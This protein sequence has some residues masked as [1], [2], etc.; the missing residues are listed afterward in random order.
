MQQPLA[1]R[2][3][4]NIL[5]EFFGHETLTSNHG[6]INKMLE[7]KT[8]VS[9][10][11]YGPPGVGKT[12]LAL[13]ICQKLNLPYEILNATTTSKKEME[14]VVE[15]AKSESGLVLI[16]DELHRLNKDK[17]DYFLPHLETGLIYLIGTTTANPY[18]YINTA[19][20]SRAHVIELK[21]LSPI[22]IKQVLKQALIKKEGLDNKYQCDDKVLDLI[23]KISGGD[24]R[25]ALNQLEIAAL[26]SVNQIITQDVII[27]SN[28]IPQS[29]IDAD[30]DGYYDAVSALQKSIRGSDVDASL[31]Y[32]ARLILANDLASIERRLSITAY[33]DI[34]LANPNA[35]MR[36]IL[37]LE[38]AQKVGFP[39]AAIPLGMAVVDLALSPKSK[40][41]NN[42]I[43]AAIKEVETSPHP[44]PPYLRLTPIGLSQDE[45]YPYDRPDLWEKI[46]YLPDAIKNLSFYQGLESSQYEKA[47]V[48]NHKRLKKIMRTNKIK[49]LK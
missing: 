24:L 1:L 21:P 4:P 42:A 20:R 16:I 39:E 6:L 47:L 19:I 5:S 44:V 23:A 43:H 33:E 25:Y 45:K 30:E 3:R 13:I 15:R 36:T 17:Q 35:V 10:I 29:L 12:S 34:G 38:T 31:Y 14:R 9:L 11:F 46:Q 18:H 8:M 49:S 28:R 40:S 7:T 32:L 2:M 22:A 37:A 48:E 27:T 26:S 41:A